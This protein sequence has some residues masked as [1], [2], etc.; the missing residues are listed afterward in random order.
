MRIRPPPFLP[1]PVVFLLI[2]LASGGTVGIV[3]LALPAPDAERPTQVIGVRVEDH[4]DGRIA[5]AWRP[6]TD[7][8]GVVAYRVYRDGRAVGDVAA[9]STSYEDV[10]LPVDVTFLYRVAAVDGAGQEGPA[11]EPVSVESVPS[12]PEV[13]LGGWSEVEP[14][15]WWLGVLNVSRALNLNRFEVILIVNG[16]VVAIPVTP[17]AELPKIGES[18]TLA[19]VDGQADGRFSTGDFFL[20]QDVRP[21]VTYAVD[22][23]YG[24]TADLLSTA[25]LI[26]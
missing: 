7:D 14:A 9:P 26:G 20:L 19:F 18:V 3:F 16:S 2:A 11:S 13:F 25:S 1:R 5:L 4:L 10:G 6:A 24:P 17:L 15:T 22:L 21:G 23:I 12:P 8:R